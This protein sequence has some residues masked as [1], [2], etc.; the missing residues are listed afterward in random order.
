MNGHGHPLK[1][2]GGRGFG[3]L[4]GWP[5]VVGVA[6]AF[7]CG[8]GLA[9]AQAGAG[10]DWLDGLVDELEQE[11]QPA[12]RAGQQ[13]MPAWMDDPFGHLSMRMETVEGELQR[14]ETGADTQAEQSGIVEDMDLLIAMIEEQMRQQQRQQQAGSGTG[15]DQPADDSRLRMR[16]NDANDLAA[17][18]DNG[19]FGNDLSAQE[20]ERILQGQRDVYPA[21]YEALVE[22]YLRRLASGEPAAG[23]GSDE[24]GDG[25]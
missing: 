14:A 12:P 11:L 16:E 20:R 13:D 25:G 5:A 22:E 2:Q 18:D 15:G 4:R 23:N 9:A 19:M 8:A 21:G 10:D 1:H 3:R 24:P 7:S 6:A 17:R